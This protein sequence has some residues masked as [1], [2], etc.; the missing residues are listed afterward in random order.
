NTAPR[1][2]TLRMLTSTKANSA[3]SAD[4]SHR[5][6][7]DDRCEWVDSL[8][9]RRGGAHAARCLL[10]PRRPGSVAALLPDSFRPAQGAPWPADGCRAPDHVAH[11]RIP[12]PADSTG[13]T[14]GSRLS[15]TGWSCPG[16]P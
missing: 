7:T 15:H 2:L 5:G 6:T 10:A 8:R 14:D 13:G 9:A 11:D 4:L 1:R 12:R 3:G 16:R